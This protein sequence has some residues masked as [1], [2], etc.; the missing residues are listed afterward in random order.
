MVVHGA[1][2]LGGIDLRS[3]IKQWVESCARRSGLRHETQVLALVV[4]RSLLLHPTV[5]GH[6]TSS[7]SCAVM[8]QPE[9]QPLVAD[10]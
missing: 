6:G 7:G 4:V 3:V 10:W 8:V 9:C 2:V 5:N 1:R